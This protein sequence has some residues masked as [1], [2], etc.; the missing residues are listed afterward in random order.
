M[1]RVLIRVDGRVQGVGF[2]WWAQGQARA[3]GLHGSAENMPDGSV[4]IDA[5]GESEA[6]GRMVRAAIEDP[7][8]TSRPGRV[9]SHHLQ[10]VAI[11]PN[12]RGFRAW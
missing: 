10:W 1:K 6:V 3:L 5:Q 2:R 9:T 11:D 12:L 8:T 7:T 4:V